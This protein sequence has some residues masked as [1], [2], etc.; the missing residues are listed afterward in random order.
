MSQNLH[1]DY[2][3]WL[4]LLSLSVLKVKFSVRSTV[5][6]LWFKLLIFVCNDSPQQGL[7]LWPRAI[8]Q[9]I[10]LLYVLRGN[11]YSWFGRTFNWSCP[12][13]SCCSRF[14]LH[15]DLYQGILFESGYLHTS[16]FRRLRVHDRSSNKVM[17]PW[18]DPNPVHS[19]PMIELGLEGL[20]VL[21]SF[22]LRVGV[23]RSMPFP[24]CFSM[25]S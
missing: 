9:T 22:L 8:T 21:W 18:Q 17:S 20:F 1:N 11:R 24:H 16:S 14:T 23:G 4:V 7:L 2:S 3:F 19:P 15:H 25:V 10:H 6:V 13:S 5:D 12:C